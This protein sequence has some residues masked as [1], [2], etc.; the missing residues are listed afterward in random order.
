VFYKILATHL[1][2]NCAVKVGPYAALTNAAE[3][4]ETA[5]PRA[6]DLRDQGVPEL[7]QNS[8]ESSKNCTKNAAELHQTCS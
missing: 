5:T 4:Q 6:R 7:H 2:T 3:V 1:K 8:P